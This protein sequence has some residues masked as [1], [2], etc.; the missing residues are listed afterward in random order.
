M[1]ILLLS[2]EFAI[3]HM[4]FYGRDCVLDRNKDLC[5]ST[6]E[7]IIRHWRG[8]LAESLDGNETSLG[9]EEAYAKFLGHISCS[10]QGSI[11]H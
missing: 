5:C 7:E 4:L 10:G 9:Y 3:S 11:N 8:N 1:I 6:N 2:I